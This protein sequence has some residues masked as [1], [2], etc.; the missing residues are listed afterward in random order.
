MCIIDG[1]VKYVPKIQ[2]I[3]IILINVVLRDFCIN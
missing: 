3:S 1:I 2:Y